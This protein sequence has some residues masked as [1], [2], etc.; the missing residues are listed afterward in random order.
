[1]I[2]NTTF[3]VYLISNNGVFRGALPGRVIG[4]L[5]IDVRWSRLLGTVVCC[6]LGSLVVG[7][8][9]IKGDA[10]CVLF[11]FWNKWI[12]ERNEKG[13]SFS[14]ILTWKRFGTIVSVRAFVF[15]CTVLHMMCKSVTLFW[16][17][18]ISCCIIFCELY[19]HFLY[20][21][22]VEAIARRMILVNVITLSLF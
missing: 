1:M 22:L 4:R 9:G 6:L 7:V 15:F 20:R 8:L 10:L 12:N 11:C 13:E 19:S 2:K 5:A 3:V 17:D 14:I 16:S 18:I 21:L